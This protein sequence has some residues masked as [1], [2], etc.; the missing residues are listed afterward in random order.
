MNNIDKSFNNLTTE[1]MNKEMKSLIQKAK[2]ETYQNTI[3]FL[4]ETG[5]I[6]MNGFMEMNYLIDADYNADKALDNLRAFYDD[7]DK[8]LGLA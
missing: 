1:E 3:K 7:L 4:E 8:K 2:A 5:S 6:K